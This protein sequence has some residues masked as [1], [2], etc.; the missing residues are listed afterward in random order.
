MSDA[1]DCTRSGK[2]PIPLISGHHHKHTQEEKRRLRVLMETSV[3]IP[4]HQLGKIN[5]SSGIDRR[6]EERRGSDLEESLG[7]G[8][9]EIG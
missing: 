1:S 5:Y 2:K 8:E 6:E 4:T 3:G 9:G 7:V